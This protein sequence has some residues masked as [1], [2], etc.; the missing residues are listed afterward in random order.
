MI[1]KSVYKLTLNTSRY[2]K[3]GFTELVS[4]FL[5]RL[6]TQF[7]QIVK[8]TQLKVPAMTFIEIDV[9]HRMGSLRV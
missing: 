1:A 3:S 5:T 6:E 4:I 9:R 8:L 2:I 7:F